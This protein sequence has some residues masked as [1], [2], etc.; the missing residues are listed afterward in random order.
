MGLTNIMLSLTLQCLYSESFTPLTEKQ[1]TLIVKQMK[2]KTCELD[3]LPTSILKK[4]L[5]IASPLI[6]KIVNAS[7]TSREFNTKWKT[8]VVRPLIK[9]ISLQVI[10][11]NFRLV[12]NLAFISKIVEWAML[13]Q[14]SQH[15]QDFNL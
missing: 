13:L 14:L 15:C 12:S 2:T 1:I 7:L 8:A 5:P 3:E 11:P 9:K 10:K 4:I 6:T